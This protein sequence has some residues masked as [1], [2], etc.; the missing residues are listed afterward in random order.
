MP[1][2]SDPRLM[3]QAI[4]A[5]KDGA[6]IRADFDEFFSIILELR[7]FFEFTKSELYNAKNRLEAD[8][9][10]TP[11][12]LCQVLG[13]NP[14][15]HYVRYTSDTQN[16]VHVLNKPTECAVWNRFCN[17]A[18][19]DPNNQAVLFFTMKGGIDMVITNVPLLIPPGIV[20]HVIKSSDASIPDVVM[21]RAEHAPKFFH[22]HFMKG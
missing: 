20:H 7:D 18:A 6:R 17:L 19:S 2:R 22:Q 15:V 10:M 8:G 9:D 5:K 1:R 4:E 14:M 21:F 11:E 16:L 13:I 12:S 3:A